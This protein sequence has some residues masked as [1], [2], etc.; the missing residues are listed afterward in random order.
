MM[1]SVTIAVIPIVN[2]NINPEFLLGFVCML[3]TLERDPRLVKALEPF[4]DTV[5]FLEMK[6]P[7]EINH[8]SITSHCGTSF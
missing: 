8:E 1:V 7:Y 4:F 2:K 3:L 5:Q 6:E